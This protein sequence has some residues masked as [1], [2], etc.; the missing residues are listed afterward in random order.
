MVEVDLGKQKPLDAYPRANQ[1]IIFTANFGRVGN[2]KMY[3][4]LE[5]AKETILDFSQ[6]TLKVL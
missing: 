2:K 1:Q 4:I 5:E 6:R 3:F